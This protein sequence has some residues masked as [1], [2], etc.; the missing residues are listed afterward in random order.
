[1]CGNSRCEEVPGGRKTC[2][3]PAG[4][5]NGAA[6]RKLL[7]LLLSTHISWAWGCM[8]LGLSASAFLTAVLSEVPWS[9]GN[10]LMCSLIMHLLR[11]LECLE[12]CCRSGINGDTQES[13]SG[14]CSSLSK[15]LF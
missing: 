13:D 2:I 14:I 3:A 5:Q 1:M 12:L 4:E 15:W 7:S 9:A 10:R 6:R 8:I 11:G